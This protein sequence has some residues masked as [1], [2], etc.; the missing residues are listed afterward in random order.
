MTLPAS[1]T[2]SISQVSVELGRAS[3]ATTS[4]GESA[5][6]TL[7][8]VASGAISLADLYGKSAAGPTN[9]GGTHERSILG[10][11][12]LT[13]SVSFLTDGNIDTGGGGTATIDT[14][15]ADTWYSPAT[16]G[17]GSSYWIR[18][19]L[20]SGSTPTSGTLNTWLQL[21]TARSWSNNS[22]A[23]AVGTRTSTLSVQV[24]S[25]STGTP[26]V[27]SGSVTITANHEI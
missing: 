2:I 17:I 24:S 6:R 19:T 18:A 20:S 11:S 26:V 16:V 22:G 14:L 13:A 8:G 21:N 9:F 23:G 3:T 1:G 5:V 4:L 25:S 12:G 7:A 10:S 15:D 27:C